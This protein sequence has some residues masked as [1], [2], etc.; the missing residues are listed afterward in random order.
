VNAATPDS[1]IHQAPRGFKRPPYDPLTIFLHWTT[2]ALVLVQLASAWLI[3]HGGSREA[4][5]LALSVHRSS[6]SAL[7]LIVVLRLVWRF[8]GMKLPPFPP[9]MGRLHITG[10]HLSEYGLYLLLLAQPLTGLADTMLRG[11]PFALFIWTVPALIARDKP[12]AALAHLAHMAGAWALIALV[13]VH[14]LAALT[15]R[16]VLDDGVLE[17]MTGGKRQP[18]GSARR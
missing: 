10:V 3:D 6:G 7:W 5:A 9:G 12:A 16:F 18:R 11:R 13:T 17:S 4:G 15:H 14:A 8:T 1:T 2:L